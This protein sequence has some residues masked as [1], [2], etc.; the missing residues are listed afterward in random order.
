MNIQ[1][2][3]I[4]NYGQSSS[5]NYGA[6]TLRVDIGPL[7]VWYSYKTPVA[8]MVLGKEKVVHENNWGSTTGKHLNWIDRDKSIRVSAETF[9]QKWD[10]QVKPLLATDQRGTVT[11]EVEGGCVTDV[12]GLPHGYDYEIDDK[13][14]LEESE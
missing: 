3:E 12:T 10:E 14:I 6:H 7:T 8:F 9:Q 2:P 11:I 13:D 4:S 5:D 1:L